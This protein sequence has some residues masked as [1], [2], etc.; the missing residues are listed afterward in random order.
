[1][2]VYEAEL[3]CDFLRRSLDELPNIN[4]RHALVAASF[5]ANLQRTKNNREL[6]ML[7]QGVLGNL[8]ASDEDT[9]LV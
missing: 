8:Q 9:V 7:I 4:K 1:M 6:D 2:S 5:I 3:L